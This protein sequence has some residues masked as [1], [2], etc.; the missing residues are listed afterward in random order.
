MLAA[1]TLLLVAQDT[2]KPSLT[3]NIVAHPNFESHILKNKRDLWV[4][5][6]P[7]YEEENKKKYPVLILHDGQNVFDGMTSFIPNK[8]W[9]ADETA[10]AMIKAG[11]IEPIIIVAV[12]NAGVERANEYLATRGK[13]GNTELGGR[14][15]LYGKFLIEEVL[16]F[17]SKKYR[18]DPR[19][20]VTGLCGSSLGGLITLHLGLRTGRFGR[21]GVVSPSVWWNNR[22]VIDQVA[23]IKMTSRP[24]IWLDMGGSEGRDGLQDARSLWDALLK[25]GWNSKNLRY[26][27]EPGAQHNEDAWARRFDLILGFLYGKS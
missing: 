17:V 19:P 3:G 12:A 13:T 27:E 11:L 20:S 6:P 9:R 15:D 16:P 10:E 21:L 25:R 4:Y 2:R 14:G 24:R 1:V 7:R 23:T 26:Y 8:E 22:E 18:I 5:L